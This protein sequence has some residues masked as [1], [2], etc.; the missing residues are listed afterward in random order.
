MPI[1]KAFLAELHYESGL[2][3]KVLQ[4]IPAGNFSWKP[5]EKSMTLIR[6]SSHIADLHL[7]PQFIV[8]DNELDFLKGN[9]Q[10]VSFETTDALL[11]NFEQNLVRTFQ[12][13]ENATDERLEQPWTLR[14]G[15]HIIFTLPRKQVLRTM[16]MNHIVHHRGQ[17]SVYLRLLNIPV[18][19]IYGPSADE[20]VF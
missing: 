20:Q 4:R 19:S 15:D 13:L 17:L 8:N 1:N 3:R 16:V 5:H 10:Q 11:L 9:I 12:V 18:P 14:R 2:T 6:L 7:L